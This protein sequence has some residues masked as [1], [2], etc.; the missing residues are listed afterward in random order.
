MNVDSSS[1]YFCVYSIINLSE[2]KAKTIYKTFLTSYKL[3]LKLI[4]GESELIK[5][6]NILQ[7]YRQFI[8]LFIYYLEF[9]SN[10]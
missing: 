1:C 8:Y 3:L 4:I 9:Y 2:A 10:Y 6:F 7:K 5:F